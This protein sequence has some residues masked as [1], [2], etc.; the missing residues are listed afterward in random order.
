MGLQAQ[1]RNHDASN[2][3][4]HTCQSSNNALHKMLQT[5]PWSQ[6]SLYKIPKRLLWRR[7]HQLPGE[8]L[9]CRN[10]FNQQTAWLHNMC[11]GKDMCLYINYCN[12]PFYSQWGVI[13]ST[14]SVPYSFPTSTYSFV[15]H[16]LR[17]LPFDPLTSLPAPLSFDLCYFKRLDK[18]TTHH[19]D[20]IFSNTAK[21]F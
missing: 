2:I 4:G 15:P 5:V 21:G 6:D 8:S 18:V 9:L 16:T 12:T 1:P 19:S 20:G 11:A 13:S 7:Q 3:N 14:S 17:N 10:K